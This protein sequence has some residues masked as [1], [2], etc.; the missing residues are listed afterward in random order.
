MSCI[1]C[2]DPATLQCPT[3]QTPYCSSVCQKTNW[4]AHKHLY[5]VHTH[6]GSY[7]TKFI[8]TANHLSK[9]DPPIANLVYGFH[10]NT[11]DAIKKHTILPLKDPT[12]EHKD[13]LTVHGVDT[14]ASEFFTMCTVGDTLYLDST[15]AAIAI[16]LCQTENVT[17]ESYVFFHFPPT[18]DQWSATNVRCISTTLCNPHNWNVG[19][20][21]I[22]FARQWIRNN[23]DDQWTGF[24]S[25]GL[26]K[27]GTTIAWNVYMVNLHAK[28]KQPLVDVTKLLRQYHYGEGDNV[29]DDTVTVH[30]N[31]LR[32]MSI[33]SKIKLNAICKNARDGL[34]AI[35]Q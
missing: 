8:A 4:K 9:A 15:L 24:M 5:H 16:D 19:P 18:M 1:Y 29:D 32:N 26:F 10:I 27:T 33:G 21:S 3:C 14:T 6:K 7:T 11:M 34:L 28:F 12:Q 2:S 22:K 30:A 23:G 35:T 31:V 17:P 13:D 25:D 20:I